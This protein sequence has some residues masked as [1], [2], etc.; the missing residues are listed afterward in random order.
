M[1]TRE[2]LHNWYN[3]LDRRLYALL[4]GLT[5]GTMG[6]LI[7]LMLAL[8]GPVLTIGAVLGALAAVYVLTSV[9]AALYGII[10]I[11]TLL[12]FGTLPFSIGFTPTLLD[13]AIGAF[14]LVYLLQWMT[15][16]RS[17]VRFTPVH[18]LV[19]VYILWLVLAFALGLRYAAPTPLILRQF[20]ETMLVLSLVF[21]L[22]DLLRDPLMLRRLVLVVILAVGT[23]AVIALAL[24][25]LPDDTAE[26]ILRVL[27]RIGYPGG[28]IIRYIESNPDL[29]ERAIG[30]WVDPNTLGGALAISAVMIAPQVFAQRPVLRWRWLTFGVLGLVSIALLLTFSRTSLVAMAAGLLVI[31]I[32]RYRKFIPLMIVGALLLLLLPQTQGYIERFVDALTGGDKA[33]QMRLGEYGDSLR[34]ISRYPVFGVGFTGTPEIGLYTDV[35][36][37]YL[38]MANQIGLVGVAIYLTTM[39]GVFVYGVRAWRYA[40]DDLELDSIHLGY[41][42]ALLAALV[43]GIGDLYYFRIDFQGSIT[44]FW[45]VVALSL[46]TSRQALERAESTVDKNQSLM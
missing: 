38:I 46:A 14:I 36:S 12:P 16:R 35:A 8:I 31:A 19:T 42:A 43:N 22:V 11:M 37:M 27:S 18:G 20:A 5:I 41:H 4:V 21:V 13:M 15:G 1:Q 30:T 9:Q 3:R 25:V 28:G 24:W 26:R 23:Q 7:G 2:V 45:L 33:T 10:L 29:P 34:L 32:A 44:L 6:G 40:R 17:F 39:G